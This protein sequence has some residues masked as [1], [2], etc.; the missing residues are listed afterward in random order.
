MASPTPG[1]TSPQEQPLRLPKLSYRTKSCDTESVSSASTGLT[2]STASTTPTSPLQSD[3]CPSPRSPP[4]EMSLPSS[5]RQSSFGPSSKAPSNLNKKGSRF[6]SGLFGVKEPSA[7]ALQ[8]YE[9][10]LKKNGRGRVSAVG[11]PGVSSAKL[12]A[13]V[14]KVN[15]KWDGVPRTLKEREKH[16]DARRQSISGLSR[17]PSGSRSGGS[18]HRATS[19]A[20][21][22]KR[23]VSR[24]TLDGVSTWSGSSNNLAELYG[25]E[26][27]SPHSGSSTINFSAEHRPTTSRS[28][29]SLPKNC[30]ISRH[31]PPAS[32]A[33]TSPPVEP[34][35]PSPSCSPNPPS[36]SNSPVL[37]PSDSSPATPATPAIPPPLI[38]LIPP[39]LESNHRESTKIA[40]LEAPG[41][42]NEVIVKSAGV[43]VLGPPAAAKRKSKPT[44][45]QTC[46]RDPKM[47]GAGFQSSSGFSQDVPVPKV[48][49]PP[50]PSLA[51]CFPN[52]TGTPISGSP[53]NMFTGH[54]PSR[55]RQ[56]L[57]SSLKN[58]AAA[59]RH[60]A[61]PATDVSAKGEKI[62]TS[63]AEGGKSLG[64]KS[65]MAFF[66]K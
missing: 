9:R 10:Q 27:N 66:R 38:S 32:L 62:I 29:P 45:L 4:S 49:S 22:S 19:T 12:P 11:M 55:E 60:Y 43:N 52:T 41:A 50:R 56:L 14:P 31:E 46:E 42:A 3:F 34:C 26:T 30:S 65:R 20:D 1:C 51:S 33:I 16:S 39:K 6:L 13:T 28:V 2:R 57:G 35:P 8:D 54:D 36:L 17:R 48:T 64:K 25:W 37:T 7:Q 59:Q 61:D 44:P 47:S 21:S 58:R 63:T 40:V 18:D 5:P 15:S 24:G 53:A 23:R